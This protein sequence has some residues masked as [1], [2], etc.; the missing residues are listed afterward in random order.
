MDEIY[1]RFR[2]IDEQEGPQ[3]RSALGSGAWN[4][5]RV[6]REVPSEALLLAATEDAYFMRFA[7]HWAPYGGPSAGDIFTEFG[8]P[9]DKFVERVWLLVPQ[10]CFESGMIA[11]LESAYPRKV[12]RRR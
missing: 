6:T 11:A 10:F 3:G 7:W 5:Y 9:R 1:R 2:R 8:I 4:E 12:N